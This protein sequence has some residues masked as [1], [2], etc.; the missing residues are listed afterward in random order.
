MKFVNK[1]GNI[2]ASTAYNG[3]VKGALLLLEALPSSLNAEE[4][5]D[6][7]IARLPED[8]MFKKA[9]RLDS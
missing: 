7:A 4:E 2:Y 5:A 1:C 6:S 8:V 9:L 3:G